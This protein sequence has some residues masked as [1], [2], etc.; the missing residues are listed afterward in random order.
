MA[1]PANESQSLVTSLRSEYRQNAP[2]DCQTDGRRST[3]NDVNFAV[4]QTAPLD[5]TPC[6]LRGEREILI[7]LY[8]EP[9]ENTYDGGEFFRW[10]VRNVL[11]RFAIEPNPALWAD[12]SRATSVSRAA[13]PCPDFNS[14]SAC[15]S[16]VSSSTPTRAC[17]RA[18]FKRVASPS[19][20]A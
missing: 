5:H 12:L 8:F 6:L 20:A 19:R 17:A 1:I 15:A 14:N 7:F 2:F 10:L 9:S 4:Q 13:V 18:S 11:A 16:W 3:R